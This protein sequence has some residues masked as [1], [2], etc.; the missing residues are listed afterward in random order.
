M[1]RNKMF[2]IIASILI[3]SFLIGC[4]HN[5]NQTVSTL[6]QYSIN[7]STDINK[8]IDNSKLVDNTKNEQSEAT[9]ERPNTTSAN[10]A[11]EK[12]VASENSASTPK[13]I[14]STPKEITDV[15]GLSSKKIEWSWAYSPKSSAALLTKYQGYAFGD[16]SQKFIY[17]TFDEGYENGYT[18]SILNTLK[19]NDVQATFFVTLPYVT[20][21]FNGIKDSDLVSRMSNEGHIIGNH[22]VHH[23]SMPSITDEIQFDAE[24]TGVESAVAKIPGAKVSKFFRPPMGDFSELSLYYTQKL[25]Y[26]TIFFSLAYKDYDVNNQ[27]DKETAKH[28]LLAS[29]KPGMICLLHAESR[30]NAEI[31]DSLIKE[32][33]N[34]GYTFKTLNELP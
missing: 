16:T 11:L 26:K 7:K 8:P 30:T 4:N 6:N 12:P 28:F 17:L 23:K 34:E 5:S 31:L 1:N 33:K 27:P 24:F 18:A 3:P 32:W 9:T 14:S 10:A 19:E 2:I 22:S 13:E 21:S 15:K 25:G 20:G 29:T